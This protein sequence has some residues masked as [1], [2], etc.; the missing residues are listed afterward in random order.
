MI[1]KA[2][3]E[4]V[5]AVIETQIEN[6]F[7]ALLEDIAVEECDKRIIKKYPEIV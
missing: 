1:R 4:T 3:A 7:D 2:V 6:N 5:N